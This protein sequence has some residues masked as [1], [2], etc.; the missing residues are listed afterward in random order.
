MALN[1]DHANIVI[2]PIKN[3]GRD[4]FEGFVRFFNPANQ[5]V[6][7]R[8][9]RYPHPVKIEED[10]N[11]SFICNIV[12]QT[13]PELPHNAEVCTMCFTIKRQEQMT[14]EG[15]VYQVKM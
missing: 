2:S 4:G 9:I 3:N 15:T 6:H 10:L 5:L 1:I 7:E 12:M 14:I 11:S 8:P 13:L